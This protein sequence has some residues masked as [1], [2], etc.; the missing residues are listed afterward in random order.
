MR[1]YTEPPVHEEE[2]AQSHWNL[3]YEK[4]KW[5]IMWHLRHLEKEI[6]EAEEGV[7]I[8]WND[9]GV[10]RFGTKGFTEDLSN[11]IHQALA[12]II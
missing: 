4:N 12:G 3:L 5:K 9:N 7:L 6:E 11:R 10:P 1:F 2:L 8:L